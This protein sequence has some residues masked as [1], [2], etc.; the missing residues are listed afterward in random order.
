MSVGKSQ[1]SELDGLSTNEVD[2]LLNLATVAKAVGKHPTTVRA[3]VDSGLIEVVKVGR[4]PKIRKS[5]LVKLLEGSKLSEDFETLERV[6]SLTGEPEDRG[7]APDD[8][9]PI[10]DNAD[11]RFR[12]SKSNIE[13]LD[14]NG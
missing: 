13:E 6:D 10:I 3:W 12:V 11:P 7:P 8:V 14:E 9:R 1:A 4:L 2:P 5:D